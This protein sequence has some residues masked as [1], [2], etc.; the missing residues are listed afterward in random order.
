MSEQPHKYLLCEEDGLL[1]RTSQE[2]A[3]YK[4]ETLR[5]YIHMTN[6]SMRD[7][8][9][10][11]RFYIDL[12]AGPGKNKIGNTVHL[13][14]PLIALTAEYPFTQYRFNELGDLENTA[15]QQRVGASTLEDRVKILHSDVNASVNPVCD[16]IDAIDKKRLAGRWPCLNVAF[17]DPEGLELEWKTVERLAQV[18]RMDM[19]INFSTSGIRRSVGRGNHEV[20]DRFFGHSQWRKIAE[21]GDPVT[22]RRNYITMYRSQ[23]EKF[24]YHVDVDPDVGSHDISIKNS[25]NAEVYSLIF[26]SKHELGDKFWRQAGKSSQ[27]PK[28]PGF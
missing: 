13:G 8:P 10:R 14:S 1:M 3:R 25:K 17:L 6:T 9:W 22:Q 2:Y 26:A 5:Y 11:D 15:L 7:K 12:Q 18:N 28:L 20:V 21:S 19:I 23:L 24:G 27:P 4:L 16:E